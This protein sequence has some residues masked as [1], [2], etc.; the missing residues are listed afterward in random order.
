MKKLIPLIIVTLVLTACGGGGGG[1]GSSA[2]P[3][4]V[5]QQSAPVVAAYEAP[6]RVGTVQITATPT[7]KATVSD[8]FTADITSSGNDSV[9][10][11]GRLSQATHPTA[12]NWVDSQITVLGWSNGQLVNQTANWFNGTNNVIK[13]TE[14]SVKFGDFLGNGK[15]GMYVAP[16]TDTTVYS[17]AVAFINNGTSF[18]R[19]NLNLGNI[20]AHD[21]VVYDF[22][23]DGKADIFNIDFNASPALS[24]SNGNGTFTT[25][26][27]TG[28]A[29]AG[30]AV[31]D[32]LGNGTTTLVLTDTYTNGRKNDA[33]VYSWAIV[34]GALQ[35]TEVA[36]LPIGRFD[37]P[38]WSSVNDPTLTKMTHSIRAMALDFDNSGTMDIVIISSLWNAATPKSEVQFIQNQGNGVFVDVTDQVLTNYNTDTMSSYNPKL[39]DYNG[40]GLMDI[41]LSGANG[42]AADSTR[43][44]IQTADHKY[45]D[46]FASQFTSVKQQAGTAELTRTNWVKTDG[47]AMNIVKGPNSQRH[48]ITTVE[49]FSNN[50]LQKAVYTSKLN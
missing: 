48:L 45:V 3:T 49:Y 13:G 21:S 33:G 46:S 28:P 47:Q 30:V 37:L 32:F 16:S 26:R 29:A 39:I 2:G 38:K 14:P 50:S 25:Y 9:I 41:F 43:V 1:G 12:A 35:L 15:M 11:A 20:W 42:V 18:T 36:T 17:E 34:N 5:S 8:I 6:V 27:G 44:L 24:F 4:S 7:D 10:I 22:N 19:V 31:G 23:G 40:D